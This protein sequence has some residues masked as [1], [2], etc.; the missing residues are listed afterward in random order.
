MFPKLL[1]TITI[2]SI[3]D[4]TTTTTPAATYRIR[5]SNVYFKRFI[6]YD[7]LIKNIWFIESPLNIL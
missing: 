6:M 7:P 2:I 1:S 3:T 5:Y 4:A